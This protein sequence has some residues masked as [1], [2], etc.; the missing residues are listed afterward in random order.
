MNQFKQTSCVILSAGYSLRMGMPKALLEFDTNQT[1]IEKI[2]DIYAS[3]GIDEVVVVLQ[4]N[5]FELIFSKHILFAEKVTFVENLHPELGRFYSLSEG[6]KT[7]NPHNSCFFQNIDNPFTSMEIL[8]SL[9]QVKDEAEVIIPAYGSKK[10][11]PVLIN[12]RIVSNIVECS[13]NEMPINSFLQ[14]FNMK[15]L[16]VNNPN[17][18]SNVNSEDDY[19]K[20]FQKKGQ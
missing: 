15:H 17:V 12:Q 14:Q 18:L 7:I 19:A 16:S 8:Y 11:H 10:G 20:W 3:A 6:L 5:L 9:I 1:F 4:P 2:T 13:S